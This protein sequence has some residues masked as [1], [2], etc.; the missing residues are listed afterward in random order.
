M[1][2]CEGTN[3]CA[4]VYAQIIYVLRIGYSKATE[5][6]RSTVYSFVS[7]PNVCVKTTKYPKRTCYI[8]STRAIL[9]INPL[10]MIKG[11]I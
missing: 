10:R 2:V 8:E 1:C 3:V 6:R 9:I 5:M 4:Y 7:S 11:G